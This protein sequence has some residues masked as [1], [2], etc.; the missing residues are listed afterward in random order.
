[1]RSFLDKIIAFFL[2][3]LLNSGTANGGHTV[4]NSG[5]FARCSSDLKLYS[6]DYLL[7]EAQIFG[8]DRPIESADQSMETIAAELFRLDPVLATSLQ[9]FRT[10]LFKALPEA[11]FIWLP[12]SAPL[13]LM[14]EPDL[15]ENLPAGCLERFQAIYFFAPV[16]GLP[17][18]RYAYYE[19]LIDQVRAQSQGELQISYLLVH[20]WLWN[21]FPRRKLMASAK[22]NRLLHSLRLESMSPNQFLELKSQFELGSD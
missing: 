12:R 17:G 5:G 2:I 14:W 20:E 4:G 13:P 21:Y 16:P 10:Y 18:T 6:Y 9:D 11:P 19:P 7:I 8:G 15:D 3:C 1:M 22:F